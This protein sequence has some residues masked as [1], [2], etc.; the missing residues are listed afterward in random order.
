MDH[1]LR[2]LRNLKSSLDKL[3]KLEKDLDTKDLAIS[4]LKK[5][6]MIQEEAI[7]SWIEAMDE[8]KKQIAEKDKKVMALEDEKEV[9]TNKNSE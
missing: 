6:I 9:L 7:S 2:E 8:K 3:K 1:E 5:K 4:E